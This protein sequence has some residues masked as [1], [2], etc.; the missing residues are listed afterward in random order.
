MLKL[1]A[2]II[3]EIRVS[4]VAGA[5]LRKPWH[6]PMKA[7]LDRAI[8]ALNKVRVACAGDVLLLDTSDPS[9]IGAL[10]DRIARMS[11]AIKCFKAGVKRDAMA[12]AGCKR[13]APTDNK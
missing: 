4:T 6:Q 3:K 1:D 7:E 13:T 8:H 5:P 10:D 12:A 9:T 11:A 2:D